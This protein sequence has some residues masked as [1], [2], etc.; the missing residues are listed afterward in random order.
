MPQDDNKDFSPR[1][2]FSWDV[3]GS[4][5]HVVRGGFGLY[6]GQT[7]LNIPLFMIQQANPT[8]F[9]TVF[10]LTNATDIVPGTGIPLGSY[11]YGVDPLPVVP[12]PTTELQDGN[13]GRLMD[14]NYRNPYTEQFNV[15]YAFELNQNNA[16]EIE[17][18]HSLGLHESKT[19]N[20]NP[21]DP[22]TGDRILTAALVGAGLPALGRVD[23][24]QSIDRS[25]Y[26]GLN[27]SYRRRMS[28]HISINS[29]YVLSRAVCYRCYLGAASFRNRPFDPY[30]PL[31]PF[32]FGYA[33]SDERHRFTFSGV[34]DLPWGFQVAPILQAA[35]A[36]PYDP[37]VTSDIYGWGQLSASRP[38]LVPV[39]NP[40]DFNTYAGVTDPVT[41]QGLIASGQ[42]RPAKFDSLRGQPFFNLDM[43]VAKSFKMG[44]KY[45]LKLISQF[46]DLTNRANYGGNYVGTVGDPS[47]GKP[48]GFITPSGVIVPQSFRAEF[49]AEFRF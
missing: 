45:N 12:P 6:Y 4:G 32:D 38:P 39:S 41:V 36:R 1:V 18:V 46:F 21:K 37:L 25:R 13:V 35:T 14:P 10:S 15:G 23:V 42:A 47:F 44:E 24:E 28:K 26:D 11:R 2:G 40:G 22:A 33:P 17:Y 16:F 31:S 20:I 5:R 34:F 3:T 19:N 9:T 29:A 8:I 48:A 30:Q 7:F 49:G 43:R 27:I